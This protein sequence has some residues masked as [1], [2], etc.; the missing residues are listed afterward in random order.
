MRLQVSSTVS[1]HVNRLTARQLHALPPLSALARAITGLT[2]AY[3]GTVLYSMPL[4]LVTLTYDWRR[5]LTLFAPLWIITGTLRVLPA[6]FPAHAAPC[7]TLRRSN[8]C[9]RVPSLPIYALETGQ[10]V[11]AGSIP[12]FRARLALRMLP[13]LFCACARMLVLALL[14]LVPYP[15][16]PYP[17]VLT[18]VN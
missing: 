5:R 15:R 16:V 11:C 3:Y 6:C 10:G 4:R 7:A 1:H 18:R 12:T 2:Q 9:F 13:N 14:D 8:L 17:L